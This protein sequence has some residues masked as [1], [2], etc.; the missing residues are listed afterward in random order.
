MSPRNALILLK[1]FLACSLIPA[2]ES[3]SGGRNVTCG[4]SPAPRTGTRFSLAGEAWHTRFVGDVAG[5]AP[6]DIASN[7][8]ASGVLGEV[9]SRTLFLDLTTTLSGL[10]GVANEEERF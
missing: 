3:S 1:L 4:F 8:C 5:G 7:F 2:R 6:R 9:D 10:T